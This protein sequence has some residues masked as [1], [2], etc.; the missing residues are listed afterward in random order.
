MPPC[1]NLIKKKVTQMNN[2]LIFKT[3]NKSLEESVMIMIFKSDIESV[4]GLGGRDNLASIELK[5]GKVFNI[6]DLDFDTVVSLL[7]E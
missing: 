3:Y 6:T 5:T 7:S 1:Y 2:T 4:M